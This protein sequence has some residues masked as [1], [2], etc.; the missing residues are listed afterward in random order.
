VERCELDELHYIAPIS[1]IVSISSLGILSHQKAR[2][3]QHE[4][5][6]M[7]VIQ[8]RR[9][10]IVV[11]NARLLHE[12]ANLY[13]CARNPM[14]F[15]RQDLHESLCVLRVSPSVLDLKGV[16]IADRNASSDHVRFAAAPEGLR[17]VDRALVFAEYWTDPNEIQQFKKRSAK[18]AEVLVPDRV[19]PRYL[20]GASVSCQESLKRFNELGVGLQA[21]IDQHMFFFSERP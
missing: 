17:I 2:R 1:S 8:D 3:V 5:V 4:S 14:L 21:R 10:K 9:A 15:K 12:Y 18:C 7:E 11:P 13:F 19:D 20:M 16:V 6:A